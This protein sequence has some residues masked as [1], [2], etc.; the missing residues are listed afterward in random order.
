MGRGE[1]GCAPLSAR[2][3]L[4]TGYKLALSTPLPHS[5]RRIHLPQLKKS[6]PITLVSHAKRNEDKGAFV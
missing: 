5:L 1:L 3:V 6:R 2:A 4:N